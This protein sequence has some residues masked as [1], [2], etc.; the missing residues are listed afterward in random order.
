MRVDKYDDL[1]DLYKKTRGE[2]FGPEVKRRII[3]GTYAMTPEQ[4][5]DYY[6][7]AQKVRTLVKNDFDHV[8]KN[9]DFL[10]APTATG[11]AF[12][13]GEETDDPYKMCMNDLYTVPANMAG[14]PGISVPCILRGMP[15][16]LQI[17]G[18]HFDEAMILKAAMLWNRHRCLYKKPSKRGDEMMKFETVVGLEVHVELSTSQDILRLQHGIYNRAV[19]L[20]PGLSQWSYLCK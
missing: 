10:I 16:G 2:G 13:L 8:L 12:K 14:L 20:L 6:L 9:Y 18:K 15:I 4:Y 11:A 1:V 3:L 7:K 19:Q 5:E 17:I